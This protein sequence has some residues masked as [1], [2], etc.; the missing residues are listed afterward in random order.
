VLDI[1]ARAGVL[2]S[3]PTMEAGPDCEA[4]GLTGRRCG[5][6]ADES[7]DVGKCASWHH[8]GE[9]RYEQKRF[10]HLFFAAFLPSYGTWISG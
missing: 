8:Q 3:N 5:V 7:G 4:A 10:P 9:K 2:N 6:D 1:F